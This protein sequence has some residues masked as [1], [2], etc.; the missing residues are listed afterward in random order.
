[1]RHGQQHRVCTMYFHCDTRSWRRTLVCILVSALKAGTQGRVD[2][3]YEQR[4]CL[5]AS[6]FH[7]MRSITLSF[8]GDAQLYLRGIQRPVAPD[9]KWLTAACDRAMISACSQSMKWPYAH[10]TYSAY[11]LTPTSRWLMV[12]TIILPNHGYTTGK[13]CI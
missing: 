10:N 3:G 9:T 8:Q 4:V 2:K 12:I 6:R 1:M 11:M 13:P 7:M 5:G